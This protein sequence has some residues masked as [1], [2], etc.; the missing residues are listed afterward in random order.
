MKESKKEDVNDQ[1]F[2]SAILKFKEWRSHRKFGSRIPEGL[3]D[4]AISLTDKYAIGRVAKILSLSYKELKERAHS[5]ESQGVSVNSLHSPSFVELKVEES[6][7][8]GL[9]F[10]SQCLME[11]N[12]ADGTNMKIYSTAGASIDLT[13]ICESFLKS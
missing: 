12:R 6:V 11:L 3:W 4:L 1:E 13:R 5:K 9:G 2:N 10:G 8:A 7:S